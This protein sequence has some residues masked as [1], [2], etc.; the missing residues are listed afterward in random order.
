MTDITISRSV[1]LR[2][3][4][5]EVW[6]FISDFSGFASWQPQLSSVEM[7]PN[8]DRRIFFKRGG[9]ILDRVTRLDTV[10]RTLSYGL[11]PGQPTP[12]DAPPI[13]K[14]DA[15]L[16]VAETSSGSEVSYTVEADVPDAIKDMLQVGAGGDLDSAMAELAKRF[17]R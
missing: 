16:V 11:V 1:K 6:K 4:A 15:T 5:A 3:G 13:K 17:N 12:P 7:L 9:S 10:N 8:G 14:M 2:A